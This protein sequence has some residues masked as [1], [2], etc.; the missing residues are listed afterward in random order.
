MLILGIVF[1]V[2]GLGIVAFYGYG[3]WYRQNTK[4][5][6]HLIYNPRIILTW[7]VWVPL[8]IIGAGSLYLVSIVTGRQVEL[9]L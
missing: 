1:I 3:V 7:I 8:T 9:D 5:A 6:E 4:Q 2:W